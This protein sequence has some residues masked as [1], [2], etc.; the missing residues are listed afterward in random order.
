MERDYLYVGNAGR[1]S[2]PKISSG[3]MISAWFSLHYDMGI[4]T[5]GC[6]PQIDSLF[7]GESILKDYVIIVV[8]MCGRLF[9]I[10]SPL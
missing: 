7:I 3:N 2:H 6:K 8:A 5:E 4:K 1:K 10:N 9:G